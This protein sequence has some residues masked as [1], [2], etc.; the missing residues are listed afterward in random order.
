M[1][2]NEMKIYC[3]YLCKEKIECDK[4]LAVADCDIRNH[5]GFETY[6]YAFTPDKFVAKYFK[7]TRNMELFYEKVINMSR[8]EYE[9]DF[10]NEYS[11]RCI[12][13]HLFVTKGKENGFYVRKD[14]KILA[15]T[16][17]ADMIL[18][19][20]G[21]LLEKFA[22]GERFYE[23]GYIEFNYPVKLFKDP[24]IQR[25]IL[26]FKENYETG[27]YNLMTP[28]YMDYDLYTLYIRVFGNTLK[29]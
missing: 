4:F 28:N 6:F 22:I 23:S 13:E 5:N 29:G 8:D 1:M 25:I 12:E 24:I 16:A 26:A 2:N 11:E 21:I 19:F 14:V 17:E 7:K 3:F 10:Y 15:P 27:F 9:N 20:S 18:D